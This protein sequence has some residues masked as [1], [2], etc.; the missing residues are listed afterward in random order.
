VDQVNLQSWILLGA[1]GGS[2][3]GVID[4]YSQFMQWH[5][6]RRAYQVQ[7]SSGRRPKVPRFR[8]HMDVVP[9][10]VASLV[11]ITLGALAGGILGG[12][13][14]VAG[15]YAAVLVGASAPALLMQLGQVK[16]INEAVG[17]RSPDVE[18][19]PATAALSVV[20]PPGN[21]RD[22]ADGA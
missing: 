21:E 8:D 16:S 10:V 1:A 6:A 5:G 22:V 17:G 11:H 18:G 2:L 7:R 14:Q 4:L 9:E 20:P 15:A 13:G 3:R 19:E 12:T